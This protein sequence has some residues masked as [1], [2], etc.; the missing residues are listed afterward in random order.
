MAMKVIRIKVRDE[1]RAYEIFETVNARGADLTVADLLKNTIF[2]KVRRD[3]R[4]R[5][6]AGEL[7]SKIIDNLDGTGLEITT[8]VRYHWLSKYPFV[9]KKQLYRKIKENVSDW[10]SFLDDLVKDSERVN[11][12]SNSDIRDLELDMHNRRINYIN[13]SLRGINVEQRN[14][15]YC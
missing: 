13:E 10:P 6:Y 14:H 12:L 2:D 9:T 5:D 1:S 7:W 11:A 8:F 15:M 3:N 4:G